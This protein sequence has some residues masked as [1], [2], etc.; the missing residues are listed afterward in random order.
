MN[1]L[2]KALAVASTF[3]LS[4]CSGTVPAYAQVAQEQCAPRERVVEHLAQKYGESLQSLGLAANNAVME[5]YASE[6]T[7]S[8]TITVTLPT[9]LTCLVASGEGYTE[10]NGPL[11][12]P[13]ESL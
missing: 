2:L 4:T 6:A 9:G 1:S 8:W 11:P 10:V 7:G 5:I 13:G 12:V 3:A